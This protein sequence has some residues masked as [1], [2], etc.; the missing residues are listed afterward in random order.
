LRVTQYRSRVAAAV[1]ALLFATVALAPA[2][3]A[4][5]IT[6]IGYIDQLALSNVPRFVAANRQLTSYK[7]SLD[8]QFSAR[9]RGVKNS[10]DQARIAQEFQ[11]KFAVK[12]RETLG[13]LFARAQVAIAS[14]ASTKNLSVVVDKRIVISG[15]QDMTRSVI[16]LFNGVGDPVPPVN[17][18]PPSNVGYVDQ[19]VI[20]QVPKVKKANDDFVKFQQDQSGEAQRKMRSAKSDAERQQIF[21]DLQKTL[22][23]KRKLTLDPVVEQMRNVIAE[24]AKK[25]GLLLVIDRSNLVYGGTDITSDVANGLK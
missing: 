1:G 21:K 8:R 14:V 22:A 5:D 19:T 25:K 6:D 13:P 20:N 16:D 9:V 2:T 10:N 3:L 12:Q 15:G 24:V 23:D 7:T 17:T 18:P 11:N 4:A